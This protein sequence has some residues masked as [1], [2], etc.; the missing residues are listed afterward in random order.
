MLELLGLL[1]PIGVAAFYVYIFRQIARTCPPER[2][3]GQL[4]GARLF[5]I[6]A[7][8]FLLL[9]EIAL[10][11]FKIAEKTASE[12]MTFAF[13]LTP[14][15]LLIAYVLLA[16]QI[17][18][19][20]NTILVRYFRSDMTVEGPEDCKLVNKTVRRMRWLHGALFRW[21]GL[22]TQEVLAAA[23]SPRADKTGRDQTA[24]SSRC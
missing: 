1:F 22:H 7:Y 6:V 16:F 3:A 18:I 15:G 10:Y 2:V 23:C 9:I 20:L 17:H 8:V 5:F 13:V 12:W 14:V 4:A 21:R 11:C 24:D 19:M